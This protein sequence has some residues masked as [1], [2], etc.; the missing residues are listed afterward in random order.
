[1]KI[2]EEKLKKVQD[3]SKPIIFIRYEVGTKGYN[4]YHLEIGREYISRD[5][6]FEEKSQW[7]WR[8]SKLEKKKG[9]FYSPNF[10][11]IEEEKN[12]LEAPQDDYHEDMR[13][14]NDIF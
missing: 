2:L 13:K 8:N 12:N 6:I 1:M 3:R 11:D 5:I 4:C 10:F 7:N 14:L 9:T